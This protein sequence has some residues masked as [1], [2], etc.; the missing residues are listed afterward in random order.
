MHTDEHRSPSFTLAVGAWLGAALL[1]GLPA[2]IWATPANAEATNIT[3]TTATTSAVPGAPQLSV[4]VDDGRTSAAAGDLLSYTVTVQNLGATP[5]SGLQVTQSMPS[6][7]TFESA[8]SAG[9]AT[10]DMVTWKVDLRATG[11]ATVHSTM[12]L[13]ATPKELLRLATVACVSVSPAGPPVVCASH[14]D[15]LPAGRQAAASKSATRPARAGPSNSGNWY[16]G[17]VVGIVLVLSGLALLI[18]RRR[19]LAARP[20]GDPS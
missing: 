4:A 5:L 15:L 12:S 1:L 6:G 9:L 20:F 13:T 16:V 7:L 10:A 11:T 17:G 18:T 8:D 14:S 19:R 2:T 3:G